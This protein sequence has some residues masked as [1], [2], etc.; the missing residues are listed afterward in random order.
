MKICV[1]CASSETIDKSYLQTGER[2]GE[3]LAEKGHTLVF[4]A[5]K[6]GIMG[7]V[8][9]GIRSK[10]GKAIGVIPKFFEDGDV[11]VK[12][13]DCELIYTETMHK[14]KFIMEDISDAF[15]IMPG[16]IGTFEEFFEVLTLKQLRR[17]AKPIVIFNENGYY[18]PLLNLMNSA[19]SKNFMSKKCQDLYYVTDS[20]ETVFAYL[21]NY[22]P[23]SYDKYEVPEEE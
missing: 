3:M 14:R 4:G 22:K 18:D 20:A 21:D 5:G 12:F 8:A 11:D 19:I 1:F 16:G 6:Y 7:A 9:R 23:Y 10:G 2:F 15:I 13:T 17:H